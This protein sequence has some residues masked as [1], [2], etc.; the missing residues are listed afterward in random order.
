MVEGVFGLKEEIKTGNT[1]ELKV[2]FWL[3]VKVCLVITKAGLL[4]FVHL[5]ECVCV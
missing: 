4:P 3:E 2:A 5:R 1:E